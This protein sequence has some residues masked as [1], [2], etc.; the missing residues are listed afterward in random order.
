MAGLYFVP[1]ALG[2]GFGKQMMKLILNEAK[3]RQVKLI[4][5]DGTTTA[6]KFY[7]AAGFTAGESACVAMADQQI[8]CIK[9][10][11]HL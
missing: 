11:M 5:L 2:Q 1:E 10:Q 8:N 3:Q 9:M 7:L 4:K 6:Q